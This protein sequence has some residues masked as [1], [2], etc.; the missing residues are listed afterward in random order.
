[1][2]K[3]TS[4]KTNP[5]SYFPVFPGDSITLSAVVR[6]GK[7]T[8]IHKYSSVTRASKFGRILSIDVSCSYGAIKV[9]ED[10]SHFSREYE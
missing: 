3:T 6:D 1:M 5:S 10:S 9:S 8:I 7:G 4:P 2:K